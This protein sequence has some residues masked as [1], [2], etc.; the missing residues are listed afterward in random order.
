[1]ALQRLWVHVSSP[2][3]ADLGLNQG[4]KWSKRSL[5]GWIVKAHTSPFLTMEGE[6]VSSVNSHCQLHDL[7]LMKY[8]KIKWLLCGLPQKSPLNLQL[9]NKWLPTLC[10]GEERCSCQSCILLSTC[11]GP[12]LGYVEHLWGNAEGQKISPKWARAKGVWCT[13]GF[14]P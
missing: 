8:L 9:S 5:P 6:A 10:P 11:Y 7:V 13:A 4:E 1:M 2:L 12:S 3:M 14:K